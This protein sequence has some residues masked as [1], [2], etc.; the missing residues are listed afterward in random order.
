MEL[1][2]E[3]ISKEY[4]KNNL[5]KHSATKLLL[6]LIENSENEK[7]RVNSIKE[8]NHI[9]VKDNYTFKLLENL[10]ISDSNE[11]IRNAAANA[12]RDNFLD[13]ALEPMRWA[14]IHEESPSCLNTIYLSL[15]KILRNFV[16]NPDPFAK[17]ILLTEIERINHKE[18]K[19]GFEILCETRE[20]EDFSKKEL[21]NLLI[22]YFSI[23]YLEKSF[24]RLK[25]KI[26]KCK[27]VKLDFIFKGLTS[28][29]E[30]IKYLSSLKILIL[31]YNQLTQLPKWMENL[32][33]LEI[34][35]INVNNLNKLSDSIGKLE[36]L[37]ELLL[38]KNELTHLPHPI[39]NL[40]NL[41]ILNLRLN[42]LNKLPETIGGLTS[43]IELN[44]HD[45]QLVWLPDSIGYLKKLE[46]LNLSWNCIKTLPESLG[47]LSSL[48]TL[49]LERNELVSLP[50]NIGSL[51]SLEFLNLS[52]N[53]LKIIPESIGNISSLQYL[54][55]SRN[56]LESIPKTIKLIT[57]LKELCIGENNIKTLPKYLKNLEVKGV[58]IVY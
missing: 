31:R 30:V 53:K 4:S 11:T 34:L 56:E 2:P 13:K 17:S 47:A 14:L 58:K 48:K 15:V 32:N 6:S 45:N 54:N 3:R 7:V 26:D 36:N 27:I 51:S 21:A 25:I 20:V 19:I 16:L 35:N 38:W 41:E 42:L 50:E 33:S 29:P 57:S 24:W 18:F 52:D 40:S 22:N 8:L 5:D 49:D 12:L 1:S 44:L 23:I 55:I 9:R 46:T 39:G 28:L 43:L 10:L 37:K